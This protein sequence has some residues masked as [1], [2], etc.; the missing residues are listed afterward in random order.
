MF[1]YK[2]FSWVERL[3]FQD[4]RFSEFSKADHC[5]W[6][7]YVVCNVSSKTLISKNVKEYLFEASLSFHF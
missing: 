7:P 1:H 4:S 3:K 5:Q 6:M 2:T